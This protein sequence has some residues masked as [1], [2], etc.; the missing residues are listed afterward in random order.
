MGP[1]DEEYGKKKRG[2]VQ[3]NMMSRSL[4]QN[5]IKRLKDQTREIAHNRIVIKSKIQTSNVF[6]RAIDS[7]NRI[8]SSNVGP[9]EIRLFDDFMIIGQSQ[10]DFE[11]EVVEPMT[12][13]SYTHTLA[14]VEKCPRRKV[15]KNFCFPDDIK[16]QQIHTYEEVENL[17]IY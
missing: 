7:G 10:T 4:Q 16:M 11:E 15:I 17:V 3:T 5:D 14:E 13:Y 2:S 8:L 9:H 1:T 6:S 12:H